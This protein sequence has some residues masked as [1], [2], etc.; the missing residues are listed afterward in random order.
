MTATILVPAD[1][2]LKRLF[3]VA[4][5]YR[6]KGYRVVVGPAQSELPEFL[7][8]HDPDMIVLS[9]ND[10]AVVEVKYRRAMMG[11][12][13]LSRMAEA[14][15]KQPGW[16]IELNLLPT[17]PAPEVPLP[18]STSIE[19]VQ[20][21]LV[22]AHTSRSDLALINAC[23]AIEHAFV[24]AARRADVELPLS[25][26]TAALKTLYAYGL[27]G[28]DDYNKVEDAMRLR[29][30]VVNG[31]EKDVDASPWI[32]ALEPIIAELVDAA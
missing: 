30:D 13:R 1:L 14:I 12:N 22:R 27:I 8:G 21:L 11:T 29:D 6:A 20:E 16:R 7:R 31:R 17:D 18:E 25:S 3:E 23:A 2:Q 9:E 19:N 24:I 15:E 26:P 32:A 28:Y 10:N 5:E 4:Q